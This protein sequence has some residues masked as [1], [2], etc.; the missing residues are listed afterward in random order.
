LNRDRAPSPA[1]GP[2]KNHAQITQIEGKL[3]TNRS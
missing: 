3:L 2:E 1:T